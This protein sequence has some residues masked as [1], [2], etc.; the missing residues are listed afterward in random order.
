MNVKLFFSYIKVFLLFYMT[1]LVLFQSMTDLQL[2]IEN[3][4]KPMAKTAGN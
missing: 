2:Q 1:I 3:M 4:T